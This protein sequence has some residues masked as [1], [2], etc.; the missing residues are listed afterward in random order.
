MLSWTE[1]NNS[2]Q[3]RHTS[4]K[5]YNKFL[6]KIV[7]LCPGAR[8]IYDKRS[9]NNLDQVIQSRIERIEHLRR[10]NRWH[11]QK[12]NTD[13]WSKVQLAELVA[14][15]LTDK[16]TGIKIRV[17]EPDVTIYSDDQNVLYELAK[18]LDAGKL[19]E[20][21]IPENQI[22][23]EILDRGEVIIKSDIEF[24]YKITLK[25]F[26]NLEP[27]TKSTLLDYLYNLGDD[28]V[29]MTKSL[30]KNLGNPER[31]W[32]PGGYFYAKDDKVATF[33]S[34]IAPGIISGIFKL[35]KLN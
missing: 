2:V 7:V 3:V 14:I 26:W 27:A 24:K 23:R 6:N 18:R 30:V 31:T 4:K 20:V 15:K 28:E 12:Y 1:L 33:V 29:C 5:F 21:F 19:K 11:Q 34:L 16:Q 9:E 32:F 35:N 17:E 25:E 8:V 10:F 13:Q 22:A